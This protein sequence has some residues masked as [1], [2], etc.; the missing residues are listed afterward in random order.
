MET[1]NILLCRS[2]REYNDSL[3]SVVNVKR[4]LCSR[5]KVYHSVPKYEGFLYINIQ[6]KWVLKFRMFF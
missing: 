1:S 6:F 3:G 4:G 5:P 2:G